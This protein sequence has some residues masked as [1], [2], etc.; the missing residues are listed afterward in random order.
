MAGWPGERET[1]WSG[2][3]TATSGRKGR[4]VIKICCTNELSKYRYSRC[5]LLQLGWVNNKKS[6]SKESLSVT[7]THN[8]ATTPTIV[9][10][11]KTISPLTGSSMPFSCPNIVREPLSFHWPM[12]LVAS[13]PSLSIFD[14]LLQ[15]RKIC[16]TEVEG[17]HIFV[18]RKGRKKLRTYVSFSSL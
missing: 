12:S 16:K 6:I 3:T 11:Y 9:G 5:L 1:S 15:I 4:Q 7:L 14:F 10:T 17:T 18:P 2:T 13:Q 8:K